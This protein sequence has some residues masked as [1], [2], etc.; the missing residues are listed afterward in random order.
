[1][2]FGLLKTQ[3]YLHFLATSRS[4]VV[5]S[6]LH[7]EEGIN[8]PRGE[9]IRLS[10]HRQRTAAEMGEHHLVPHIAAMS[11][12]PFAMGRTRRSFIL[13]Q[14]KAPRQHTAGAFRNSA[15]L[16]FLQKI[17]SGSGSSLAVDVEY[18]YNISSA[19]APPVSHMDIHQCI[20]TGMM[21]NR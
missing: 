4:E 17:R 12:Y 21:R 18:S 10:P 8:K 7:R 20:F 9:E 15:F 6:S 13:A 1:V 19:D 5:L 2:R 11:A 14:H 16:A 3:A